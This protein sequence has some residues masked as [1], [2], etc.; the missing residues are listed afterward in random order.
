[1]LVII[2]LILNNFFNQFFIQIY[3]GLA[4]GLVLQVSSSAAQRLLRPDCA[5]LSALGRFFAF[6]IA[7]GVNGAVWLRNTGSPAE[8]VAIRSALMESAHIDDAQA[9]LLVEQLAQRVA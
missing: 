4:P 9:A 3:G 8:L 6:E 2:P 5:V 7:V 1:M